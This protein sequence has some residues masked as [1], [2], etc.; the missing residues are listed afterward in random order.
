VV[1]AS[2]EMEL[3]EIGLWAVDREQRIQNAI[4]SI[5]MKKR[6]ICSD[7]CGVETWLL[8]VIPTTTTTGMREVLES[9]RNAVKADRLIVFDGIWEMKES[10]A[11]R[12][13]R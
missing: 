8:K 9:W 6:H 11:W 2:G 4:R 12:V 5:G 3:E 10:R 13:Q 1:Q 7:H